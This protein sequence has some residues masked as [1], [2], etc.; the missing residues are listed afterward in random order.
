MKKITKSKIR[1]FFKYQLTK[2]ARCIYNAFLFIKYPFLQARNVWTGKK[3][4]D[5]N[6][7]EN[8]PKGWRKAFGKQFIKDLRKVLIRTD[9]LRTFQFSEIKEKYGTLRLDNNGTTPE[10]DKVITYYEFLSMGYCHLCGKPARY[11]TKG[12]IEYLCEDCFDK[13]DEGNEYRNNHDKF[14]LACRLTAQDIPHYY[15][16]SGSKEIEL[17]TGVDFYKLWGLEEK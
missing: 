5:F 15:T 6:L 17:D 4:W 16:Y 10:V 7:L 8:I 12:W 1:Y 3:Y 13:V 11:E 9:M 14:K 2:P